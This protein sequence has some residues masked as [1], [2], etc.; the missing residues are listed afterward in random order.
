MVQCTDMCNADLACV[1]LSL[2][3]NGECFMFSYVSGYVPGQGAGSAVPL[4][5]VDDIPRPVDPAAL[6]NSSVP[7]SILVET[8]TA[9]QATKTAL[10]SLSSATPS[11]TTSSPGPAASGGSQP[12]NAA[13][14]VTIFVTPSTCSASRS[15][16][17]STTT[18]NTTVVV[19]VSPSKPSGMLSTTAS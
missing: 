13:P 6:D 2:A 18:I 8:A 19:I 11:A 9:D 17:F 3:R 10:G 14:V 12:S 15:V 1:G 7:E 5:R 4:S 16:R